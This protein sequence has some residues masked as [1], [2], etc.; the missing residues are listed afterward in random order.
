M[1]P[2]KS[3]KSLSQAHLGLDAKAEYM[4][5][6]G[7]MRRSEKVTRRMIQRGLSIRK[8]HGLSDDDQLHTSYDERSKE[9]DARTAS[10]ARELQVQAE[11]QDANTKFKVEIKAERRKW[12]DESNEL[13]AT[14]LEY[15]YTAEFVPH[16]DE[17]VDVTEKNT[18]S[19]PSKLQR[20][21]DEKGNLRRKSVSKTGA[22][23]KTTATTG[24]PQQE[25]PAGYVEVATPPIS[26]A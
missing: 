15:W 20:F 6:D 14:R 4:D 19:S 26:P 25:L 11:K 23:A 2:Q 7:V 21:I 8:A 13:I 22:D 9:K 17:N 10:L 12:I 5:T 3:S 16:K 1:S 24:T 18:P